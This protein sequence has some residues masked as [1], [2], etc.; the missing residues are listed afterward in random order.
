MAE[1]AQSE[2]DDKNNFRRADQRSVIR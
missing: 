1:P 2:L